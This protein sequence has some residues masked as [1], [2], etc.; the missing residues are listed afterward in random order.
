MATEKE[1]Q[2]KIVKSFRKAGVLVFKFESPGHAGV[3]DLV[4]MA[5]GRV[6]FIEVKNPNGTGRLSRLQEVAIRDIQSRGVP[7]HVINSTEEAE[8]IIAEFWG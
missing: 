8:A 4:A 3:P 1:L 2:A 7:V 6:V 5:K